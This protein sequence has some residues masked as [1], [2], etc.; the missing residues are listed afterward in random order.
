ML[1]WLTAHADPT[2]GMWGS[3]DSSALRLLAVNGF[4]R[5]TRG[6]Y[7][8]FDVPL[9]HPEAAIDTVLAHA[10]DPLLETPAGLTACNILDIIHPLWLAAKQTGHRR[11]EGVAWARGQLTAA[12]ERWVDGA[13]FAFATA[14][15]DPGLQGT[16]M[17]LSIVYLMADYLGESAGLSWRPQ[18]VHRL[19]L[20]G[21]V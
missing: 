9:P 11:A 19:E 16:E 21:R 15:G 14:N 8:Q 4:Y 5:L 7:A 20:V 3:V 10:A 12:L 17:W 6:A 18:G 1:G 13:G 2:T